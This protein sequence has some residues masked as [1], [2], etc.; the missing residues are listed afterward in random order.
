M[1]DPLVYARGHAMHLLLRRINAELM[2]SAE[3]WYTFVQTY[4]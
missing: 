2:R 1:F 3:S 4:M